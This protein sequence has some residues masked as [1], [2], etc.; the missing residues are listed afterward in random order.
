MIKVQRH[1]LYDKAWKKLGAAQQN[2]ALESIKLYLSDPANK[3]LRLHRLK[4][5][6]YPQYSIS[7][8]GDLR[9]HLLIQ[10]DGTVILMKI[11]THAQLYE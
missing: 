1:R 8:G 2:R 3:K 11:G 7:A 10:E 9:I 6:H 4:G 5:E